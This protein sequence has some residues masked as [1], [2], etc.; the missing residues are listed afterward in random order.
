MST[1][2]AGA[3]Q[4]DGVFITTRFGSLAQVRGCA[5]RPGGAPGPIPAPARRDS[6]AH[7]RCVPGPEEP[8][9]TTG[10]PVSRQAAQDYPRQ[11]RSCA[12]G[13][14]RTARSGSGRT[15]SPERPPG[16]QHN[17]A[18]SGMGAYLHAETGVPVIGV[19]KTLFRTATH[20]VPVPRGTSVKPLY[21]T[22]AGVAPDRAVALIAGMAGAHRTPHAL[23]RLDTLTR[24]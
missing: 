7:G 19:A 10:V 12:A 15:S 20:A 11:D 6:A 21:T 23:R 5:G 17:G 18:V 2:A 24:T 22:A 13:W 4:Y 3:R 16:R 1:D 8:L 9:Q 14:S